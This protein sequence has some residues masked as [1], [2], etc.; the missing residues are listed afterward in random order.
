MALQ[1]PHG[2]RIARG[3]SG[4]HL[5]PNW[6][7]HKS[8]SQ[9]KQKLLVYPTGKRQFVVKQ[10]QIYPMLSTTFRCEPNTIQ[11][12][13]P[14]VHSPSPKPP[15][16]LVCFG[17]SIDARNDFW[18]HRGVFSL[19]HLIGLLASMMKIGAAIIGGHLLDL[20]NRAKKML[21]HVYK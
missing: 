19:N 15:F 5:W 17:H 21:F 12:P 4:F 16:V 20:F 3:I 18:K 6:H 14:A 8:L 11:F 10:N 7:F 2:M 13:P 1:L 9:W